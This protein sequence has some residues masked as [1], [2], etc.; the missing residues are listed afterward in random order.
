MERAKSRSWLAGCEPGRLRCLRHA[1]GA[2]KELG[3]TA[4]GWLSSSSP[5]ARP[6]TRSTRAGRRSAG[7]MRASP[8]SRTVSMRVPWRSSCAR[9]R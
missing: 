6:S 3:A 4:G 7:V 5:R 9:R 8:A 1:S 2:S